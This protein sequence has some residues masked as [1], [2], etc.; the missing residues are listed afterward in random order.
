MHFDAIYENCV[1]RPIEP[2][3][4]PN[5]LRVKV[6]IIEQTNALSAPSP[7]ELRRQSL[8]IAASRRGR[9]IEVY[10]RYLEPA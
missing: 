1:L 8:L 6:S 7:E 4:L 2:L 9:S 10:R 5:Y 3:Q